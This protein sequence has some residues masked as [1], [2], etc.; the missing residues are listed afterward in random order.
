MFI[1]AF[2]SSSFEWGH[3]HFGPSGAKGQSY[4]PAGAIYRIAIWRD[5]ANIKFITEVA[6]LVHMWHRTFK[7]RV[8][9]QLT[10]CFADEDFV[11]L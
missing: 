3:V 5:I 7:M 4:L 1:S 11:I 8:N 9:S 6:H 2:P 10:A